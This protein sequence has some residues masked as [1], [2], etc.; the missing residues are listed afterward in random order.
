MTLH[1]TLL[2]NCSL[3]RTQA[4]APPQEPAQPAY[5]PQQ[6]PQQPMAYGQ[7]VCMY[8]LYIYV[9]I[10]E[11][12]LYVC[13]CQQVRVLVWRWV[14]YMCVYTYVNVIFYCLWVPWIT[15]GYVCMEMDGSHE[16]VQIAFEQ[17]ESN[18]CIHTWPP[19]STHMH[20]YV[21]DHMNKLNTSPVYTYMCICKCMYT[22]IH[23]YI[24]THEVRGCAP[25]NTRSTTDNGP[26]HV[27]MHM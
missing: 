21:C 2:Y 15:G 1:Q 25:C 8:I 11:C 3:I 23:A 13:V 5:P 10:C 26:L 17:F 20:V 4:Y 14:V 16:D 9:C 18:A 19:V 6:P 12:V 27:Y 22:Y 24:H 7:Q